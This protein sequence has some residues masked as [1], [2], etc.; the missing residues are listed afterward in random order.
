M[1]SPRG[2]RAVALTRRFAIALGAACLLGAGLIAPAGVT[3]AQAGPNV[4]PRNGAPPATTL[5][6]IHLID[7][8]GQPSGVA[9]DGVDDTI[10]VTGVSGAPPTGF[11]WVINGRTGV[12]DDT[13]PVGSNP[14]GVAVNQDDDTVYVANE[15]D[16]SVSVIN[17]RTAR[18][19]DDTISV[20]LDPKSVAVNQIDDTVY[21]TNYGADN[22]SVINGRT[23]RLTDDT[24]SVGDRPEGIAVNQTD[25][26]VYVTNYGDSN[27]SVINGRT[28]RL[29]DDTISVGDRPVRVAIN[30]IDDTVYVTN[31]GDSNVSVINGRT[32]SGAS[33]I[34]VGLQPYGVA[35]D[36]N[37][38]TAY[39]TNS[40][41][42]NVSI[43]NG[44]NATVA[45]TITVGDVPRGVAVDDSGA[46]QGLVYVANNFGA[47]VSVIGRVT[48]S[49]GSA[50]GN[51]G[52]AV[53]IN[54]N[55]PQVAY[56]V[57]DSTVTSVNF[58][59]TVFN[60]PSPLSGDAWQ[61]T[62][63]AGAPG[64]TVPVT[65]T[66][67][68]GL[69]AS[70]GPFTYAA[71]TPPP[72][73]PPSEPSRVTAVAGDAQATVTWSAPASS[74]SFPATNYEV[75]STPSGGTCLT[76][77][78]TCTITGLTNGMA[79]AF[80]ARALNGAGWGPWST[81]SNTITPTA[82]TTPS[83]T[84]TGSRGTGAERRVVIV[85]G[86]STGL[87]GQ[88]VRAHVKLRG[89][90]AYRPGRFVDVSAEGRFAWQRTTGKKTYVYFTGG[91][92]Q[93]KRVI[94]PA[95]RR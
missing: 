63:P 60:N 64:T 47:S 40:A 8:G 45:G 32:P 27:V 12:R 83:I 33:S 15:G 74:G 57:D 17:G 43:I 56:D 69:T 48:P 59:G 28:A 95:A 65:V 44:Q 4:Q 41:S 42:N 50:S 13:I 18:L 46:N 92:V 7:V 94:I 55:V 22:V 1:R 68:G 26:T 87:S 25:D 6:V 58:G 66:F 31:Y 72:V 19:T 21:V 80:E 93:S 78:L 61:I 81:P 89:Q 73:F 34:P 11:V 84:I 75:R 3:T 77:M 70:A 38:A 52:D 71:P 23:A 5:A 53:T 62:A 9:V 54:V 85:T 2:R 67:R 29:T 49:L 76:A 35:V 82:R 86:T 88:E 79:Y 30:Q 37:D 39:V 51:T 36:Q 90:A 14:N 24:I 10:Y 16:R 91:G 20:G